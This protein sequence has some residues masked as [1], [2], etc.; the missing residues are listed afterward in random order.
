MIESLIQRV[1]HLFRRPR[2]D[3]ETEAGIE[4]LRGRLM[5]DCDRLVEAR[6][7]IAA[8]DDELVQK[9]SALQIE[10]RLRVI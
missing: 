1:L 3:R 5:N 7:A 9:R 4:R 2:R 10:D 8:N 6:R